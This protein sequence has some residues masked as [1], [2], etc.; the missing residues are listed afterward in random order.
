[1][2]FNRYQIPPNFDL[3]RLHQRASLIYDEVS[4]NS[5]RCPCCD[6][7]VGRKTTSFCK[8]SE[9]FLKIS[10]ELPLYFSFI[11]AIM[12]VIMTYSFVILGEYIF[13]RNY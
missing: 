13:S 7:V 8:A 5:K 10:E 11:K 9:K 6:R 2:N 4:P 12:I 1:M 3:C